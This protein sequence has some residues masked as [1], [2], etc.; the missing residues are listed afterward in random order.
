MQQ[1]LIS[2]VIPVFNEASNIGPCYQAL[3]EL[4]E[5]DPSLSFEFIFTDNA[6]TDEGPILIERLCAEDP[7][8]KYVRY[9]TNVGYQRSIYVGFCVSSGAAVVE[10]DCDLE[11]PPELILDFVREW[12]QGYDVV[13]G[14][15]KSRVE[16]KLKTA[17]RK[18]FYRLM[19]R[20]S[21]TDLPLDAGDFRLLSRRVVDILREV[22]ERE[23]YLRGL[24]ASLGFR[25]TG[26]PYS[27]RPRNSGKTK[28]NFFGNMDLALQSLVGYSK[29]PMRLAIYAG[30]LITILSVV[31]SVVYLL[32]RVMGW[33]TQPG[34]TTV[35]ITILASWSS[36]LLFLGLIGEYIATILVQT[37]GRPRAVIE[38]AHNIELKTRVY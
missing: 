29:A 25:Q 27:R 6:S 15:R 7:R 31:F 24:V 11:D 38:K 9:S 19:A 30:F 18:L 1:N 16:P 33:I 17:F 21:D 37:R 14:V 32:C 35:I 3:R 8:V 20:V 22:P 23:P 26:I 10:L 4:A 12:K 2:V 5:K 36:T 34:F 13:Y 28:F